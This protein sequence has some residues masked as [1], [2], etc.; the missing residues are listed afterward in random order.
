VPFVQTIRF[1]SDELFDFDKAELKPRAREKLD[2]MVTKMQGAEI[3]AIHL[4]GYTD[5]VGADAYND[6]LS[7]RRAN[8]VRD[9]M[10]SKGVDSSVIDTE[11]RG[12]RDPVASN[13]TKDGRAENRRVEVKVEGSRTVPQ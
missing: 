5:S 4:V 12:K 2:E 3:K 1:G 8:A 11:G 7:L 6:K 9:Y 13:A 10:V